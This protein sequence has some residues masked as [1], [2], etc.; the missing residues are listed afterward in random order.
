[1]ADD[2][3]KNV[4]PD[5]DDNNDDDDSG[6]N[7]KVKTYDEDAYNSIK[8]ESIKNRKKYQE[9]RDRLKE[10][11]DAK[12]SDAEKKDSEILELKEQVKEGK[13]VKLDNMILSASS[14]ENFVDL[15]V[16][17][18]LVREELAGE[19]DIDSKVVEKAIKKIAKEKPYLI[20]T[21]DN[22][23]TPSP[24]NTEK[25]KLEGEKSPDEMMGDFL[26]S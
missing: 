4:T 7:Q 16:V 12:L 1:M 21:G 6:Q 8:E 17:K 26:H 20:K 14:D 5:G 9:T 11:E 24:G 15:A 19:D 2:K 13:G 10:L 18:V 25:T 3:D 22:T 23:P